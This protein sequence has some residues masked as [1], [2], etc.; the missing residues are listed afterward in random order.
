MNQESP[1]TNIQESL[2]RLEQKIDRIN[3][4]IN[5][6]FWVKLLR[7]IGRNFF[8]IVVLI[9]VIILSFKAWELYQDII[10]RI[11]EIKTVPATVLDTGKTT[12]QNV[13]DTVKFW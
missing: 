9:V 5:P 4:T 3:R 8:T 1:Y 11:E 12:I 6:P 13:I 2:A 10:I 7:W